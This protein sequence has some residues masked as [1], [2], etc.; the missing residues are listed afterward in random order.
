[1]PKHLSPQ[2]DAY[3]FQSD[4]SIFVSFLREIEIFQNAAEIVSD[5]E[6]AALRA[7]I[8]TYENRD[9][10]IQL[11]NTADGAPVGCEDLDKLRIE[12]AGA[13]GIVDLE[14]LRRFVLL[15]TKLKSR[16][17]MPLDISDLP[18]GDYLDLFR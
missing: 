14:M 6:T 4:D 2:D 7:L 1:M 16:D 8:S 9:A 11:T 13:A 17:M 15:D 3:A 5:E 10:Q 12:L 18:D